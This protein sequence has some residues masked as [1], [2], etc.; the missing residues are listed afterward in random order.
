MERDRCKSA[1]TSSP[2]VRSATRKPGDRSILL[3]TTSSITQIFSHF[4][5]ASTSS[6][7]ETSDLLIASSCKHKQI[8]TSGHIVNAAHSTQASKSPPC[9]LLARQ[10]QTYR[11]E[12]RG[13]H[14][15]QKRRPECAAQCSPLQ[16]AQVLARSVASRVSSIFN[17]YGQSTPDIT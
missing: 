16:A 4:G 3:T 6:S 5:D 17:L 13:S 2:I 11:V 12:Y 9:L 8:K 7:A 10:M 14:G 15:L 1:L